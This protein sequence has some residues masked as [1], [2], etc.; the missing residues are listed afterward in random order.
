MSL[1]AAYVPHAMK[2]LGL[3]A[4]GVGVTLA[5]YGVGMVCLLL[6]TVD[7]VTNGGRRSE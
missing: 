4:Q 2:Q 6:L 5:L 7:A 3:G 1:Q